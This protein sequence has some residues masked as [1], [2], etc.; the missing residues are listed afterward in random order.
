M[1]KNNVIGECII[2]LSKFV[3]WVEKKAV[4]NELSNGKGKVE[5]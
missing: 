4:I 3:D 1:Q 2:D 5:F